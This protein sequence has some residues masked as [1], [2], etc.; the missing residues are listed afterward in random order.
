MFRNKLL[1]IGVGSL[2]SLQAC[3]ATWGYSGAHGPEHWAELSPEY[4]LCGTGR[5]QSPVDVRDSLDTDLEPIAFHYQQGLRDI[6]NNGHTVQVDV[7]PGSYVMVDGNRYELKQFHFHAPSENHVDGQAFPMEGHFVHADKDGNLA[8]VAVMFTEQG[9]SQALQKI[10]GQLPA[11]EG[12]K[13]MLDA[14]DLPGPM[15]LLPSDQDY[16]RFN[17][18]LTTPPCSE[19]VLWL[20]MKN[21]VAVSAQQVEAFRAALGSHD[22]NRPIQ[23][24]NAR[25]VLK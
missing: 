22:N 2:M 21:P 25:A 9:D 3:A 12:E 5:N 23:P 6:V 24:L 14:T 15:A 20:V 8:V 16:Y 13:H 10:W 11:Q 18:S 1:A 17:G 4:Q 19:G 7:Q